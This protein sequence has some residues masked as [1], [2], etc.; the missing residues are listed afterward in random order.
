MA[1]LNR[2]SL[3]AICTSVQFIPVYSWWFEPWRC[4]DSTSVQ[5]RPLPCRSL[6]VL[7]YRHSWHWPECG[8]LHWRG[9]RERLGGHLHH[10]GV[11]LDCDKSGHPVEWCRTG[12]S[13]SL[14]IREER[15]CRLPSEGWTCKDRR[16]T[17][18]LHVSAHGKY[19]ALSLP[20]VRP[21][22]WAA[23]LVRALQPSKS[24]KRNVSCWIPHGEVKVACSS[25][26]T[27]VAQSHPSLCLWK[28]Q[29]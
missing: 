26:Q 28:V 8:F 12:I 19:V 14:K 10:G 22:A 3:G 15:F 24:W 25:K 27:H 17:N 16:R 4:Q 5:S 20:V 6:E 2:A 13:L 21:P 18:L 1:K 29:A 11:R 9:K 23:T 7:E